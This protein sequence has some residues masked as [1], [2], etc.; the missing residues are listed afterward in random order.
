MIYELRTYTTAPGKALHYLELFR[1]IGLPLVTRHLPMMGYWLSDAGPLNQ[2]VHLWAYED[3]AHR[4]HCRAKLARETE[5]QTAFIDPAFTVVLSQESRFLSLHSET[6]RFR[7]LT[8][9]RIREHPARLPS[10]AMFGDSY[11]L[12][13]EREGAA[14]DA[15]D[16]ALCSLDVV[17]GRGVGNR[18]ILSEAV[19][20]DAVLRDQLRSRGHTTLIRP[21]TFSP[22]G[23]SAAQEQP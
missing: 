12:I 8:E 7:K 13:A 1:T 23:I 16:T 2:I 18:I 4:S 21:L 17:L 5:W 3:I 6:P 15:P 22:I 20:V 11:C 10:E 9:E 19:N 14:P